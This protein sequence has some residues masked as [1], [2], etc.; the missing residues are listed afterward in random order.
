MLT[1]AQ[2]QYPC[3]P[4]QL[5]PKCQFGWSPGWLQGSWGPSLVLGAQLW[6]VDVSPYP[7]DTITVPW[8]KAYSCGQAWGASDP[9][10]CQ[11]LLE[12]AW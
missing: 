6:E 4:W 9:T 12:R 10:P 1:P 7:L 2:S 5:E 11:R 3:L 8:L